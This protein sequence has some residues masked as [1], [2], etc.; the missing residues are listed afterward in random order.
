M[1][2]IES[3][4]CGFQ[5][6]YTALVLIRENLYSLCVCV[7][8]CACLVYR[9]LPFV[10]DRRRR[11]SQPCGI[12]LL[13][14]IVCNHVYFRDSDCFTSAHLMENKRLNSK[15]RKKEKTKTK[16]KTATMQWQ[17]IAVTAS[18]GGNSYKLRHKL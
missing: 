6:Q 4:S 18:D 8:V 3:K 12:M 5:F 15:N 13:Q 14:K 9:N 7:C 10:R 2:G 11:N 17:R 16:E 1:F